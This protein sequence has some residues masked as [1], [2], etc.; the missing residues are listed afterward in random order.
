ML[1]FPNFTHLDLI[2]PHAVWGL[3]MDIELVWEDL[4][5]VPTEAGMR[6]L[7][8]ATFATCPRQVD[9]LFVP[10]GFGTTDAIAN[11][12]ALEFL[13]DRGRTSRYVTS[14]C[15]GSLLLG[16]AGLL[17]GYRAATH[18]GFRE[19]LEP[20]GAICSTDRVVVD[21]NRITGGGVTA[22]IDF[23]LTVLAEVLG[24]ERAEFV[25][26]MLEY[27]PAPPFSSGS[28]DKA[29]PAVVNALEPLLAEGKPEL[30]RAIDE[31]RALRP[32]SR[33]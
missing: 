9:I 18:W 15:T 24:Q 16:A 27:D 2:G 14:V 12:K 17:D 20:V 21:R 4:A 6:I 3:D 22:G 26:L 5:P 30:H 11:P 33:T 7:P 32:S 25:Q 13:A 31:A 8:T 23:G 28:P 10:G 19:F 1:M 29:S